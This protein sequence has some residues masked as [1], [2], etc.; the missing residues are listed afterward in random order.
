M[1]MNYPAHPA[2]TDFPIT[3]IIQ[4]RWSPVIFDPAPLSDVEVGSLFEAARWGPSCYNEQPWRFVYAQKGDNGRKEIEG[5]LAEGNSWAKNAGMLIVSFGKKTF[6]KNGKLNQYA[7][8][9]TGAANM[10]ITLQA[11]AMGLIT[12]Q[13]GGFA[14]DKANDVLGVPEDF[15]VGSM[16]AVGKPGTMEGAEET[17]ITRQSSPRSRSPQ[18]AFVF[19]GHFA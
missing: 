2:L 18:S 15:S 14:V 5:L 19:K 16:M 10:S 9:D 12:H 6:T 8:F 11:E 13:M 4:N 17:L 3:T 7:L 1:C